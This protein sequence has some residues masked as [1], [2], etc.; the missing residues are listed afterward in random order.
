MRHAYAIVD[1]QFGSTGKGLLAGYL[2]TEREPDGVVCAFGPNAGH[3]FID[4]KG[5]K[6]IHV[7]LPMAAVCGA[8]KV[9]FGPGTVLHPELLMSEIENANRCGFEFE[10]FIHENTVV[11]QERHREQEAEYG[12]RIGSTMKGTGAA[13]AE[14]MLRKNVGERIV[15]RDALRN[16]PLEALVVDVGTYNDAID[17]VDLLQVEGAQ[18][19][20][21]SMYHGFY[22][23]TTSRDCTVAQLVADCALPH[24][25]VAEV[26]GT[27]RTFPIRVNNRGFSSGPAYPDQEEIKWEQLGLEPELTTVT[28]L[29]RRI[30][31][32]SAMQVYDAVRMNSVEF[33]FLN[34]CNYLRSDLPKLDNIVRQIEKVVP[35]E[36]EGWGPAIGDV[37]RS[38]P[39]KNG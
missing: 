5:R 22:P 15:A 35:V 13:M 24:G 17:S 7:M 12:A 29:P 21:L 34:F 39:R 38:Y 2:A 25:V 18:G 19:F 20:S 10:V 36:L 4:A 26:W 3:T 37:R 16:T 9:F 30:F 27:A 33:L 32:F 23:Y 11:V 31:T 14:R 8:K 1:L 6:F 28:K